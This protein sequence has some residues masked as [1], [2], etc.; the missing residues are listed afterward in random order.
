[1]PLRTTVDNDSAPTAA[2]LGGSPRNGGGG[3]DSHLGGSSGELGKPLAGALEVELYG[4]PNGPEDEDEEMLLDW[5][6]HNLRRWQLF[7]LDCT[8]A[9]KIMPERFQNP[10]EW[11]FRLSR[12]QRQTI[13][14]GS[15]LG[16]VLLL[17]GVVVVLPAGVAGTLQQQ[18]Q[19]AAAL[20]GAPAQQQQAA[21]AAA[22]A[23]RHAPLAADAATSPYCSWNQLYLPTVIAPDH[24]NLDLTTDPRRA[25]YTVQGTARIRLAPVHEV[26]PCV[27]VHSKGINVT[28]VQLVVGDE[29]AGDVIPGTLYNA[30]EYEQV[31]FKFNEAVPLAPADVTLRIEFSYELQEALDGFY[32][33]SYKDA[34]GEDHIMAST[35]FEALGA[36]KAF[37]CFDEPALKA[38]FAL[39]L[40]TA[41]RP[42]VALSN[43]PPT[44]EPR[45]RGRLLHGRAAAAA[46]AAQ[47]GAGA[48]CRRGLRPGVP[49]R[50]RLLASDLVTYEF[51]V[52]PRMSTYLVAFVVGELDHV[53][54]DCEAGQGKSVAVSVWATPDRAGQ[55]GTAMD[56]ACSSV[57]KLEG[58]LGV[59]YPLPKLD[60]VGIPNF[61]A[62]AMENWGL[63]MYRESRLLV[64]PKEGDMDQEY[65]ISLVVAHEVSHLWFGDLVTLKDWNELWLNEGF[66]TYFENVAADAFRP[67]YHYF[68]FF[69]TSQAAPGLEEDADIT[70]HPLSRAEPMARLADVENQFDDVS[71]AKGGSVLRML[72]A[73]LNGAAANGA[74][75]A[76]LADAG[77]VQRML[78]QA[79]AAAAA[80]Q[81][82]FLA[83]L[84]LYLQSRS[85]NTSTYT[86]LWGALRQSTG[87][88]VDEWMGVWTLRR[89]FP[90]LVVD[91]NA[92]RVAA[93]VNGTG[94][95]GT[96]GEAGG[97]GGG[98][99]FRP[100]TLAQLP[101]HS[102]RS[103]EVGTPYTPDMYCNDWSDD[104]ADSSWWMPVA[105]RSSDSPDTVQWHAFN[106]CDS[107]LPITLPAPAPG[108]PVNSSSSPPGW[109]LV[110]A[111]RTGFYRVNYSEALWEG[112][113]EAAKDSD[114][115][116]KIDLAGSLDDAF[117]L[118]LVRHL[119]MHV[120]LRLTKSLGRRRAAEY[121]PWSVALD[122][123]RRMHDILSTAGL[124]S[125]KW[126]EC[127][128][129]LR[130]YVITSVTG[131]FIADAAVPNQASPGLSLTVDPNQPAEVRLM[132][133]MMMLGAGRLGDVKVSGEAADLVR[134]GAKLH[135]DV[136]GAVYK[137]AVASG[138]SDAY[139]AVLKMYKEERSAPR[140]AQ[141][142]SALALAPSRDLIQRSL[143][144]A[145][146]P[147]VR[148]Q[149]IGN[150]VS[151]VGLQGGLAFNMTWQFVAEKVDELFARFQGGDA[152][153]SF[154][155]RLNPLARL[156]TA[157]ESLDAVRSFAAA[158]PGVLSPT[159]LDAANEA[160]HRNQQWLQKQGGEACSWLE[161]QAVEVAHIGPGAAAG[162]P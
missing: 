48:T 108:G 74:Q 49:D 52:T 138:D 22:G 83:G 54:T 94:G 127:A 38:T 6:R 15:F 78:K 73:Y 11:W 14:Y 130:R 162:I 39:T 128:D 125:D 47:A 117:A 51:Q 104:A 53:A 85:F 158:H 103:F 116:P 148:T 135:P 123:L 41:P 122:R 105:Y 161:A 97:D 60:L 58:L 119:D 86:D 101:Y 118:G 141:L 151:G 1:M 155:R 70:S 107:K 140:K 62:G 18:Q 113:I 98:D 61:A 16:A 106:T 126:A 7:G 46:A 2:L 44:R 24:Y 35:H 160:M 96:G 156:F 88:P 4:G 152:M 5:E 111:G 146:T 92:D 57:S 36:R 84:T 112:L 68:D 23:A 159:F 115:I 153:Y 42:W 31:V 67:D 3:N 100:V 55:L 17:I 139:E 137:L 154:G 89:G 50:R 43:M 124:Q 45:R 20:D 90:I 82:P 147:E 80:T 157:D 40:L 144:L 121:A 120:F 133:P 10:P 64:D 109:L 132:R 9:M 34:A 72:R 69:L 134:S 37:P 32:R 114:K 75:G 99:N 145:L 59:P 93:A 63:L 77:G 13:L 142:L 149:D 91:P 19:A 29:A 95:N 76:A 56:A 129:E 81:D 8:C 102:R 26:T 79:A 150:L 71:Y 21:A 25:P 28:S 110:N 136:R 27:V 30:T 66:A 143:E 65:R 33:S 12:L 131:P 87:R